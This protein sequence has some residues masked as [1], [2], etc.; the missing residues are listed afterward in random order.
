MSNFVSGIRTEE[1]M[2]PQVNARDVA[3]AVE[4]VGAL[5]DQLHEMTHRLVLLE[6]HDVPGTNG[7]A[8][9]IRCEAA[10]LRLDI[11][12]AQ[13]LIDRLQ[14]RHLNG[15]GHAQPR[16]LATSPSAR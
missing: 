1:A 3:Q 11:S 12:D 14:R 9:A 2:I 6:C 5:R 10:A 15:D 4:L 7:P 8:S 13:F 16:R